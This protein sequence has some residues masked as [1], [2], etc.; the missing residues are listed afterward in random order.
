[1]F[2]FADL[3]QDLT[4]R[5]DLAGGS[6]GPFTFEDIYDLFIFVTALWVFGKLCERFGLPSVVG[7]I[8][9]GLVLG[10]E[11][12][13]VSPYDFSNAIQLFGE[14]GLILLVIEA[15][16]EVDIKLLNVIG[17]RGVLVAIF[18][19]MVPVGIGFGLAL[20]VGAETKSAFAIGCCL[21]PTSMGIAVNVLKKG[22]VLNSEIG[23][24][25]IAS[26]IL[27][28]IISLVLLGVVSALDDPTPVKLAMPLIVSAA[29]LLGVGF[30]AF[31]LMPQLLPKVKEEL[32]KEYRD[33]F[34]L[35]CV[36]SFSLALIPAVHYSGSSHLLGSFLAGLCFCFDHH[37]HELWSRQM[38]RIMQWL[39]RLFFGGTIAFAVPVKDIWTGPIVSNAMLYF[40]AIIGKFATSVWSPGFPERLYESMMLGSA[41]SAWG[42]F[43]FILAT[44]SHSDH[45][46]DDEQFAS[47]ILAI[48]LSVIVG[49]I[50]LAYAIDKSSET[51]RERVRS[52]A[53]EFDDLA[54]DPEHQ[55]K[56]YFKISMQSE[57]QWGFLWK[58]ENCLAM[59]DLQI[60][61][62]RIDYAH[63]REDNQ[64][65]LTFIVM[66][67][68]SDLNGDGVVSA[69]ELETRKGT[70]HNSAYDVCSDPNAKVT[71]TSWFPRRVLSLSRQATVILKKPPIEVKTLALLD[72]QMGQAD[73]ISDSESEIIPEGMYLDHRFPKDAKVYTSDSTQKMVQ[74][75]NHHIQTLIVVDDEES[76]VGIM[77]KSSLVQG[78]VAHDLDLSHMSIED[79]M[80]DIDN[81]VTM[82]CHSSA[83]QVLEKMKEENCK[84]MPLIEPKT[85]CLLKIADLTDVVI[86]GS[87]AGAGP[88][89]RQSSLEYPMDAN[90]E[91]D[92]LALNRQLS[93]GVIQGLPTAKI[94]DEE[95]AREVK[96]WIS[97][98]TGDDFTGDFGETL[99]SGALLCKL[100]NCIKPKT[101]TDYQVYTTQPADC[102]GNIAAYL[103]GVQTLG[104]SHRDNFQVRDLY[105][106]ANLNAVLRSLERLN[107][108]ARGVED[109]KGP[110]I[111]D[112][113]PLAVTKTGS[114]SKL[115]YIR[116]KLSFPTGRLPS[117][118]RKRKEPDSN[119]LRINMIVEV[120]GLTSP[121]GIPLNGKIGVIKSY[122]QKKGRWIVLFNHDGRSK[123]VKPENLRHFVRDEKKSQ[124]ID[125]GGLPIDPTQ[126]DIELTKR[127]P[128]RG[129]SKM[130]STG[131]ANLDDARSKKAAFPLPKEEWQKDSDVKFC[132]ICQAEFKRLRTRKHHCRMCGKIYCKNC[133]NNTIQGARV[134]DGCAEKRQ[135]EL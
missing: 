4:G 67:E 92:F 73:Q 17:M 50:C 70:I 22:G 10:P 38:K 37:V 23:Q 54:V 43:A 94:F 62:R 98:V 27:D 5:R 111:G 77:T 46:I 25:V 71:V 14:C 85:N 51:K 88:L 90:Y 125:A 6:D 64:T 112:P 129:T 119:G 109:F 93:F 84:H 115:K 133:S 34:L 83:H 31:Y 95:S 68:S 33:Y 8:V 24:L 57:V 74:K 82:S 79:L 87:S 61:D 49:P 18:G 20:A 13:K 123:L 80:T 19:S 36:F 29:F 7:E 121:A 72:G 122:N 114:Q 65:T 55:L 86:S 12:L 108:L 81:V 102:R 89:L 116:S 35:F 132:N 127:D 124:Y 101:V 58:A 69:Q 26:A 106:Y 11:L 131:G 39:L 130:D 105:E 42:E 100:L 66:D 53:Q 9:T 16:L 28:D 104:L 63:G 128:S 120:F 126:D 1:M 96:V 97:L 44:M 110:F 56:Q 103:V 47:V 118:R 60:I 15:G 21:A 2:I 78:L 107:D 134:C 99:R 3:A 59:L 45:I 40:V 32:P 76:V 117:F 135:R 113:A 30:I 52:I 48:L 41:M 91:G 75:F